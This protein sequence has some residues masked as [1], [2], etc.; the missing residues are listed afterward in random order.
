MLLLRSIRFGSCAELSMRLSWLVLRL[1]SDEAQVRSPRARPE[2]G[3]RADGVPQLAAARGAQGQR[4]AGEAGGGFQ[5][6]R[7]ARP[8]ERRGWQWAGSAAY[9]GA[10]PGARGWETEDDHQTLSTL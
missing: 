7:S 4:R 5:T 2:E 9:G 1:R 3:R 6:R 10:R 8:T